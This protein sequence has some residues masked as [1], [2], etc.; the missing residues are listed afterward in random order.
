LEEAV[1][2]VRAMWT[3]SPATFHGKYFTIEN[4]YCEPRPNP[5]PPFMIGGNGDRTMRI[6]AQHADWWN[7]A[8]P[9]PEEFARLSRR[10]DEHCAA[11][12]RTNP[13]RKTLFAFVSVNEDASKV[14]H[15]EGMHLVAGSA[16]EVTRELEGYIAQGVDYLILRFVDFP[17]T[18]GLELFLERVAPRL[19]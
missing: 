3:Q 10:L 1:Q 6:A 12:G 15:R 9:P 18:E 19:M 11:V 7:A 13:I 16:D 17:E 14:Q 4:A 2:I 5:L 8:F